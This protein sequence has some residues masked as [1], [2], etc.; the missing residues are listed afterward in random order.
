[1][2]KILESLHREESRSV[3]GK[4]RRCPRKSKKPRR[5]HNC[6]QQKYREPYMRIKPVQAKRTPNQGM[7]K[8]GLREEEMLGRRRGWG[9]KMHANRPIRS[10]R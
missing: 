10:R 6:G 4:K 2:K 7:R 8:I 1:V 3:L 9:G 5:H